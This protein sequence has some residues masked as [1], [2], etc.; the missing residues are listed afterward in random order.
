[1]IDEPAGGAGRIVI[2]PGDLASDVDDLEP[3]DA[4]LVTHEHP[5]HLDAS[6]LER[7]R[8]SNP[9][10]QLYGSPGTPAVLPP[11]EREHEHVQILSGETGTV[12]TAVGG[13]D[14]AAHTGTH[15]TIVPELPT[16][17]NN[18]YDALEAPSRTVE[19]LLLPIA[20]PG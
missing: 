9:A 17:T 2:D 19:I 18:G 7:L 5:D 13:W 4:V 3:V 8:R 6:K 1:M 16:I 12:A 10:L 11:H 14:V 20:A 15:A